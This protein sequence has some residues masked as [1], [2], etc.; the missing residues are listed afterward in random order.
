MS[1]KIFLRD[2]QIQTII[3]IYDWE[4]EQKQTVSIDLTMPGDIRRAAASDAIDATLNYKNVA[5][6]VIAFTEESS[7]QLV[8]TLAESIA[9]ICTD[10][11]AMA[12]VEVRI[13]K[14]GA[15]RGA[16]DVGVQ[17]RRGVSEHCGAQEVFVSLGSNVEPQKNLNLALAALT[18]RFGAICQST[19]YRNKAVGFD[20]AP[21][22]NLVVGFKT[23]EPVEAVLDALHAVEDQFGR[24]RGD[25]KFSPR[26]LDM[27]LLLYG[28]AVLCRDDVV[29]PRPELAKYAFM[30]RPLAEL[31]GHRRDPVSGMPFA[32]LW[33]NADMGDHVM[34]PVAI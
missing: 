25:E 2:L 20:G 13:S 9:R 26:T 18:Q 4:R 16:R 6:R 24:D 10:E 32:L 5:K 11:F 31:A 23:F 28:D 21:F 33:K 29:V 34:T 3:G 30:L 15:I 7:F 8:E 17:I 12:W 19:V 22:L 27:D 14:P 1:D